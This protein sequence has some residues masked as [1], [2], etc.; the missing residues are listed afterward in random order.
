MNVGNRLRTLRKI[1]GIEQKD[2]AQKLK[3][4]N[5]TISS[6]ELNRT[7]PQVEDIESVCNILGC[8]L[9]D[10]FIEPDKNTLSCLKK[11]DSNKRIKE[12][13]ELLQITQSEFCNKT[14]IAKSALSN[15]LNGD[16]TPRLD[17]IDK[18][19]ETYNISPSWLLGYDV[20]IELDKKSDNE[21]PYIKH[22]IG[23]STLM[24]NFINRYSDLLMAAEGCTDEQVKLVTETLKA[25]NKA[26]KR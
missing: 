6:W 3:I 7:Q 2:L 8:K 4:S 18:I 1:Y 22:N 17:Q 9:S 23:G 16:R 13:L 19:A 26:N 21:T 15:Y 12:L 5:R 20:P 14:G 10:F 24:M 11:H 25:F